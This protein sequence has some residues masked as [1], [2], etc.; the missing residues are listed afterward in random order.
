MTTWNGSKKVHC[1]LAIIWKRSEKLQDLSTSTK[2][3]TQKAPTWSLVI[4]KWELD[5]EEQ[6]QEMHQ[7]NSK[8]VRYDDNLDSAQLIRKTEMLQGNSVPL[9]YTSGKWSVANFARLFT[10]INS[11]L[12]RLWHTIT[13]NNKRQNATYHTALWLFH[14]LAVFFRTVHCM[15][16]IIKS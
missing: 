1:R 8:T 13:Q 16:V 6:W 10:P 14:S 3:L 9:L 5:T 4:C 12:P 15:I 7:I 2:I 11:G